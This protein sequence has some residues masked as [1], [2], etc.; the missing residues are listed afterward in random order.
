MSELDFGL[1]TLTAA[2]AVEGETSDVLTW[3]AGALESV[4]A[5]GLS[6]QAD[7]G[8]GADAPKVFSA[9][10]PLIRRVADFG[11]LGFLGVD[12]DGL[13]FVVEGVDPDDQRAA[14][15]YRHH[16]GDVRQMARGKPGVV[17]DD[18]VTRLPGVL[19]KPL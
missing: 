19:R 12:E 6:F 2:D 8:H 7:V 9:A 10:I 1:D 4:A 15:E 14:V 16:H 17:G 3:V 11:T 18:A 5:L 13:D